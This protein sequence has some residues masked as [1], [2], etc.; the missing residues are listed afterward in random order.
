MVFL[1]KLISGLVA[2]NTKLTLSKII[3]IGLDTLIPIDLMWYRS[4]TEY[5]IDLLNAVNLALNVDFC[6]VVD[7][8]WPFRGCWSNHWKKPGDQS[9]S[10]LVVT[11]VGI[12][13]NTNLQ[14]IK[15]RFRKLLI[16]ILTKLC[17]MIY[18][19]ILH[20][21]LLIISINVQWLW[22]NLVPCFWVLLQVTKYPSSHIN[23]AYPR[24]S[25]EYTQWWNSIL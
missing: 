18:K 4:I 6:T 12:H 20:L 13:K 3:G 2:F 25:R 9:P 8:W 22:I 7:F 11:M 21:N 10:D 24:C 1:F 15:E 17:I 16:N 5:S 14:F 23:M 19:I